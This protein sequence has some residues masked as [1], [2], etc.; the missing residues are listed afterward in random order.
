MRRS[1][2]GFWIWAEALDLLRNAE[3]LQRRVVTREALH[4]VPC[5]EPAVDMYQRADELT[6]FVALP[7]VNPQQLEVLVEGGGLVVHGRRPIPPALQRAAIHRL[8]IPY[9]RFERRI[10]LPPGDF[11][12][13]Q[14]FFEDGCLV[15]I[16]H[17]L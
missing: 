2:T 1:N 17:P 7:G 16:L 14:Q 12:V 3:R 15:L 5:W 10:A 6:L 9:G 13:H 4:R 11:R 8:E